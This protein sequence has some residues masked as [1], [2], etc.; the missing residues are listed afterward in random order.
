MTIDRRDFLLIGGSLVAGSACA[1]SAGPAPLSSPQPP[2]PAAAA[3]PAGSWEAVCELFDLDSSYIH[4]SCLF[5]A[6]HPRPVREAID[7]HRRGLDENP[8]LYWKQNAWPLDRAA[9]A[10]A[11]SFLGADPGE[12]AMTDSTTMG[13]GLLYGGFEL[14]PGQEVLTTEHDHYVTYE[15]LRFRSLRDGASV[16]KVALFASSAAATEDEIVS[17][18]MAAVTPRTRVVAVTWVHSSTGMKLP[19]R[20]MA[21]ALARANQGRDPA[22]R[23]LLCVDGVHGLGSENFKVQDLGCDFFAAGCHKWLFGPRGTGV[24]WGRES[25]WHNVHRSIPP[26]ELEAFGPWRAGTDPERSPGGVMITP[27]GFHSFEYRWALPPAFELHDTIGRALIEQRI[28]A[29]NRQLKEGLAAMKHVTLH[30]P[31]SERLSSGL[32]CFEV[33]GMKPDAVI[34]AL[35]ENKIIGSVT[36]YRT[37]YARLTPGLLNTPEQVDMTLGAVRALA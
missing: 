22:D 28:H 2:A 27:G 35:L 20:A 15:A 8:V 3:A 31:M 10:A 36:F 25:E 1:R 33:A 29:L 4:M 32:T 14:K 12:V 11:A 19:I 37:P 6:S 30:T 17:R 24:L 5:L 16:R 21:E 18:L 7:A 9:R 23:A 34:H 13:L 26:F